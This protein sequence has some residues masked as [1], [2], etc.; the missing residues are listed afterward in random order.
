MKNGSGIKFVLILLL[1]A[2]Y[3]V[4][5]SSS[6]TANAAILSFYQDNK[7]P[8]LSQ[9]ETTPLQ[10]KENDAPKTITGK[11]KVTDPDDV[12]LKSAFVAISGNYQSG[13]DILSFKNTNGITGTWDPGTGILT[14]SGSASVANYQTALRSIRYFNSSDNP[15]TPIRTVA[16]TVNDGDL[17]SIPLTRSIIV[18]A[19]NDIPVLSGIETALLQYTEDDEAT[20]ITG[21]LIITDP[22]DVNIESAVVRISGNYK[23][24]QDILSFADANGITGSWNSGTGILNL[25]GT[26]TLNNYQSALRSVAYRNSSDNPS[27]QTRTVSFVVN[28][29][30]VLSKA[31]TRQIAIAVVNDIPILKGIE[32]TPLVY[33]DYAAAVAITRTLTVADADDTNIES[34]VVS[35]SAN[36]QSGADILSFTN[37]SGIS[38]TWNSGTGILNLTGR[39]STANYQAALR[40]ITYRNSTGNPSVLPRTVSF[41]VNDGNSSSHAV[42][43]QIIFTALNNPPEALSLT[44]SGI[45]KIGSLLTGSYVYIDAEN[46]PEGISTFR[47][48]RADDSNGTG[49]TAIPGATARTYS[50]TIAD[51]GK[52]ISFEVTP[53]AT[54]GITPG[55]AVQS[56]RQPVDKIPEGWKV[57]PQDFTNSGKVTAIVFIDGIAVESGLLAAFVGEECRG[58]AET[59]YYSPSGQYLFDL[60]CYSNKLTGDV[61][62]FRYYS[63]SEDLIYKMDRSVDFEP[64][65]RIGTFD[66][67]FKMNNGKLYSVPLQ[68]GW[69]WFSVNTLLDNMTL[70]FILSSVNTNGDYIKNQS[71][72]ST[73]FSGYGWFGSL[74]IIEPDKLY[75]IDVH[76]DSVAEFYGR[77]AVVSAIKIPVVSGWNWIGYLPQIPMPTGSALSSLTLVD[78]DYIKNQKN[79]ATYYTG[80]GW[81]GSLTVMEPHVGYMLK[82]SNSGTLVYPDSGK[83]SI[84]TVPQNNEPVLNPGDFEFSGEIMAKVM[85]DGVT[86]GSEEDRLYAFVN[87]EIR[88][89]TRGLYFDPTG[90]WL[91]SLL[92]YSN[93]SRGEIV[94]FKYFN[95]ENDEFYVCKETVAFSNDMIIANAM[96]PFHLNFYS[97]DTN[98]SASKTRGIGML[99]YPNPFEHSINIEYKIPYLTRVRITVCD[100][101]GNPVTILLDKD[102]ES[103]HY[104]S[105]WESGSEPPGVYFIKLQAGYRLNVH[106]VVL[107][108]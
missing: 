37:A 60:T 107:M 70:N 87:N 48:Y 36:Y 94:T 57:D 105:K 72:S 92:I 1:A 49:E 52:Y 8:V 22:D 19:V 6:Q 85:V 46:D 7:A 15:S 95:A 93:L 51:A 34:A 44:F 80:Y 3:L 10:Y 88:G 65:M 43:R 62:T 31:A 96:N 11:I 55:I 23:K 53:A 50:L 91:Y 79:S 58:I 29:G 30:N 77:P 100:S 26:S 68:V 86:K 75:K 78:L 108:P 9:I 25:T 82:V 59:V 73:Y 81:F 47:W 71:N 90:T 16:F 45:M 103:G 98:L 56:A 69:N 12:N 41:T 106:K 84:E 102:L 18:T 101:F 76:N 64:D 2:A 13:A 35:I 4:T 38:G 27:T 20:A 5:Q 83:N 28:D 32:V 24:D 39:S 61:L 54:S 97:T 21:T 63:V 40:S 14:L 89:I 104:L 66:I 74:A 99:T 17:N 42:S 67:P 33:T